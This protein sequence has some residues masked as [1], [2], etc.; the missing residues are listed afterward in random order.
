MKY[1]LCRGRINGQDFEKD[2]KRWLS[3]GYEPYGELIASDGYIVQAMTHKC[4]EVEI[5]PMEECIYEGE[6][7]SSGLYEIFWKEGGSSLAS[8]GVLFDGTRWYAPCN[9]TGSSGESIASS[10]WTQIAYVV[11]VKTKNIG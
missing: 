4:D 6:E 3:L 9:W 8:I 7:L 11:P 1:K 2:M 5:K 10:D